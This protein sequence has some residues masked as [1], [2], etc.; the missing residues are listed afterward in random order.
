MDGDAG[1]TRLQ[2][3]GVGG[4]R[5]G[6]SKFPI[7]GRVLKLLPGRIS[8]HEAPI[9]LFRDH[10][11]WTACFTSGRL[12]FRSRSIQQEKGSSLAGG[13]LDGNSFG[14][15]FTP[16]MMV[17][18]GSLSLFIQPPTR[19]NTQP[20]IFRINLPPS[21]DNAGG[22]SQDLTRVELAADQIS[23]SGPTVITFPPLPGTAGKTLYFSYRVTWFGA[24][25]RHHRL[26]GRGGCITPLGRCISMVKVAKVTSPS[27]PTP[28]RAYLW[29]CL[30]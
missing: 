30:G 4:R 2:P 14:Q 25:G 5:N 23:N 24:G 21:G 10:L 26:H 6:V 17:E 27:S 16:S 22:E 18:P 29:R 1:D 11:A 13:L 3:N 15:T 20:V 7:L 8:I 9:S 28:G 19:K 12:C